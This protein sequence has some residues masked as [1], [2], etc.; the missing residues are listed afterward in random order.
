MDPDAKK[1]GDYAS[2]DN[3]FIVDDDYLEN[4][5]LY[6]QYATE[7]QEAWDKFIVL[8]EAMVKDSDVI[9]GNRADSYAEF[10]D[11]AKEMIQTSISDIMEQGTQNMSAYVDAIDAADECLY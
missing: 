7:A 4:H 1:Y 11:I 2:I 6:M 8:S 5:A 3:L 10:I 9:E